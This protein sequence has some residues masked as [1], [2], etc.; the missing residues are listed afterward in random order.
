MSSN[1]SP[2]TEAS[3]PFI[4][5][6]TPGIERANRLHALKHHPGFPDLVRITQDL[7]QEAINACTRYPGW[8]SQ[9]IVVLKVRQQC[10]VEFHDAVL[11]RIDNAIQAGIAE[12]RALMANLPE[13]TASEIV[14]QSDYVRQK[15]LESFQEQDN[16]VAGSY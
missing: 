9:Q 10:A 6:T 15:V 16:R 2:V 8:D 14:D 5:E 13:K 7:V 4:Q 12:S 11:V 3:S 1:P